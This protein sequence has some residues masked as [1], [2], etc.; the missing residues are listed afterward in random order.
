MRQVRQAYPGPGVQQDM[1]K[2]QRS[3][4][5]QT[6]WI[7]R[8]SSERV[9][10]GAWA[11]V[12]RG[13]QMPG[14]DALTPDR[15]A[16]SLTE[17]IRVL[18]GQLRSGTYL[19][20][21]LRVFERKVG[22]RC[23]EFAMPTVRDRIAQRGALDVLTRVFDVHQS[24][25]SFAYR[26][27]H[28]WLDAL[29]SVEVARDQGLRWVYRFDISSF[30]ESIDHDLLRSQVGETVQHQP[31]ADLLLAWTEAPRVDAAGVHAARR[32]LPLGL[33]ISAVLANHYL[34]GFDRALGAGFGRSIRYADD[35]VVLCPSL[36][37]AQRTEV[38]VDTQLRRLGLRANPTK[39]YVSSFD[40]GFS[41]LGWTF[42]G[43]Y[44]RA[45]GSTGGWVHPMSAGR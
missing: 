15:F 34:A 8:I 23:R 20:S 27:G 33:P 29:R 11:R 6:S 45:E 26:R 42:L 32:G 16:A 21:P 1:A 40:R 22:G 4:K 30:F 7:T 9:L 19:P 18:G 36:E 17:G 10:Y 12:A 35:G 13:S 38:L 31:T 37:A 24:E 39:S 28:S 44:G 5:S 43:D 2:A 41:Y 25:W 14:V 3:Q